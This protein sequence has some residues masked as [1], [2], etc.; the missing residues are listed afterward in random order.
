M[1]HEDLI[2]NKIIFKENSDKLLSK[3]KDYILGI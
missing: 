3:K 2:S 1:E